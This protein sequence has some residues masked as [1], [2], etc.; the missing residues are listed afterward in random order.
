MRSLG[1]IDQFY[2][3]AGASLLG[4]NGSDLWCN[5]CGRSDPLT[6][7]QAAAYLRRGWPKCCGATMF[8]IP[9]EP[10]SSRRKAKPEQ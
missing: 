9:R 5:N 2:D 6:A 8:L 4:P 7:D 3:D 1:D 10:R